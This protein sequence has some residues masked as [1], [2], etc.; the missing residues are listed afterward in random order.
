[1]TNNPDCLNV[2]TP[3]DDLPQFKDQS[4]MSLTRSGASIDK[5]DCGGLNPREQTNLQTQWLDLSQVYDNDLARTTRL[6]TRRDGLMRTSLIPDRS[7]RKKP[8][9]Q[10]P[11]AREGGC[12]DE[13]RSEVCFETGDARSSQNL[14]LTSF[15]LVFL[16]E[17]NRLARELKRLN[18]KWS[19]EDLFQEARRINV[20]KYQHYI[21]SEW[22]PV[23]IGQSLVNKFDLQ[24]NVNS[25]FMGYNLSVNPHQS[26][27]FSGAAFR[28]GHSM[29]RSHFNKADGSLVPQLN[30]N[31]TLIDI[32][33]RPTEAYHKGGL[34]SICRGMLS[35]TANQFDPHLSDV[36]QNHLFENNQVGSFETHRF[37]LS[38]INIMRGR[39]H[40]VPTYNQLRVFAGLTLASSFDDLQNE[41][42]AEHL[43]KLKQA[44]R[45]VEDI[46]AF[47]GGLSETPLSGAVLGPTFAHIVGLQFRDMKLG[48]RFFYENGHDLSTRFTLDQLNEIRK[49]TM[50]RLMCDNLDV[51]NVIQRRAFEVSS[52]NNQLEQCVNIPNIDLSKWR[53][54]KL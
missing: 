49:S 23:L 41:I 3:P 34:D 4:C 14:L 15:H 1:M 30:G 52:V 43:D 44:Y 26:A 18:E 45:H 17:H 46:D 19:D 36:M 47:S 28:F 31:L 7:N 20:A 9:E 35:N 16:R 5:F 48:D 24:T 2:P 21:Y 42:S 33:L 50:S 54:E 32:V 25:Y 27:E 6:R 22:I 39:D 29:V 38:T 37:S 12:V 11:K 10:L 40:G 51:L 8:V 53:N 13:T